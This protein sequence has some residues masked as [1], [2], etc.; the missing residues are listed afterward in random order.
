MDT[1][2]QKFYIKLDKQISCEYICK[3]V[4]KIVTKSQQ[5][6]KDLSESFLVLEIRDI[7]YSDSEPIPKLEFK[8]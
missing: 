2:S 7:S 8:N 1:V 4:G 6:G 3:Q 5:N